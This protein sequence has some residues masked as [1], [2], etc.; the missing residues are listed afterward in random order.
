MVYFLLVFHWIKCC[1]TFLLT[2]WRFIFD[3]AEDYL[4]GGGSKGS[5]RV[6]SPVGSDD[7]IATGVKDLNMAQVEGDGFGDASGF[8]DLTYF[9]R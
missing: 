2:N 4:V 6:G 3:I 5:S 1:F 9:K 7:N 8:I